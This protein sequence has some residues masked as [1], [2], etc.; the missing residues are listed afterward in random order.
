KVHW[1]AASASFASNI[2]SSR[3]CT[4]SP[5]GIPQPP[6][7]ENC[8]ACT[9]PDPSPEGALPQSPPA[10]SHGNLPLFKSR[11]TAGSVLAS[12]RSPSPQTAP[13]IASATKQERPCRRHGRRRVDREPTIIRRALLRA[14]RCSPARR[15]RRKQQRRAVSQ[16]R[17]AHRRQWL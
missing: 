10:A 12:L 2:T 9:T 11:S 1:P 17:P 5:S 13:E 14:R 16:S 15:V 4:P 8:Q 7:G 3:V 6:F